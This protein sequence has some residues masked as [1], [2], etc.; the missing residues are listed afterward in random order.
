LDEEIQIEDNLIGWLYHNAYNN[1]QWIL[2]LEDKRKAR[3]FEIIGMEGTEVKKALK[4]I[5]EEYDNV[6]FQGVYDIENCQTIE[7]AIRLL[8]EIP[9]VGKQGY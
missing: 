3:L 5:L 6:I 1:E 8:N 9:V 2:H 7:H 4:T